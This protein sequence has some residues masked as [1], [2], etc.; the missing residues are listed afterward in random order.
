M[1]ISQVVLCSFV[2]QVESPNMVRSRFIFQSRLESAHHWFVPGVEL[3]WKAFIDATAVQF[4]PKSHRPRT[5]ESDTGPTI[6]LD[7]T[8]PDPTGPDPKVK[9]NC[10]PGSIGPNRVGSSGPFCKS[11]RLPVFIL[12]QIKHLSSKS[13]IPNWITN[14]QL[15]SW[16][17]V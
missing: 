6:Y 8:Q 16:N 2:V 10:G 5:Q 4:S 15:A 3:S 13:N 17:Y 14:D 7:P 9:L 11:F 1:S 12:Q